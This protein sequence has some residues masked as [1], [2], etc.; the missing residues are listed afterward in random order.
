MLTEKEIRNR[1]LSLWEGSGELL[2]YKSF[3]SMYP[4]Y[5]M[6]YDQI[7]GSIPPGV[8]VEVSDSVES[9]VRGAGDGSDAGV[10]TDK[11]SAQSRSLK[12]GTQGKENGL[13]SV[14]DSFR[15]DLGERVIVGEESSRHE[16]KQTVDLALNGVTEAGDASSHKTDQLTMQSVSEH[17][18]HN[19]NDHGYVQTTGDDSEGSS[20]SDD[21]TSQHYNVQDG[22]Y[23]TDDNDLTDGA[24]YYSHDDLIQML[25][26]T[27]EDLKNQIYWHV[28]ERVGDWLRENPD[29]PFEMSSL[30]EDLFSMA[31]PYM[32]TPEII[33]DG[34]EEAE[35]EELNS[36]SNDE[37]LQDK[38]I[39]NI[40]FAIGMDLLDPF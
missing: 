8:E 30:D 27:H 15:A 9:N 7:T 18:N 33:V 23:A 11:D 20:Q 32:D 39:Y 16:S 36:F 6:Y 1:F 31:N 17:N 21:D 14:S 13:G 4:D 26:G 35:Q 3:V 5:A 2:V 12:D 38:G 22:S 10:T 25:K 40:F 37:D 29:K 19:G 28:K 34:G 24:G